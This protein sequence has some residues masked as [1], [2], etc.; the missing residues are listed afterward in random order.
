MSEKTSPRIEAETKKTETPV[1][2]GT[3]VTK[4]KSNSGLIIAL[5]VLILVIG[6]C[7]GLPFLFLRFFSTFIS[8]ESIRSNIQNS[9]EQSIEEELRNQG[10]DGDLDFN[11]DSSKTQPLPAD[12]PA[13][14][15]SAIPASWK[16]PYNVNK[17]ISDS[18]Q[19]FALYSVSGTDYKALAGEFERN[20]RNQGWNVQVTSNDETSSTIITGT[21]TVNGKEFLVNI[22]ATP[23]G[24]TTAITLVVNF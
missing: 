13:E 11:F 10:I 8:D 19:Y 3:P 2:T 15:K 14:V 18:S 22:S 7:C 4:K 12:F 20:L 6:L 23:Q 9:I 1:A 5:I 21:K 24:D 17:N 16:D